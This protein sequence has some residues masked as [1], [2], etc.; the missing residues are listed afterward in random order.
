MGHFLAKEEH[1]SASYQL[2]PLHEARPWLPHG[3]CLL[4]WL[5]KYRRQYDRRPLCVHWSKHLDIIAPNTKMVPSAPGAGWLCLKMPIDHNIWPWL[6]FARL[7]A[8]SAHHMQVD[9]ISLLNTTLVRWDGQRILYPNSKMA[10]DQLTN[11]SR[12]GKQG[13]TIK[14]EDLF[15][16]LCSSRICLGYTTFPRACMGH[17]KRHTEGGNHCPYSLTSAPCK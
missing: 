1:V 16:D 6:L 14:V 5:P 10:M 11:V 15:I 12:S 7:N 3:L 17:V 2:L 4:P 9:E 8:L 13:E